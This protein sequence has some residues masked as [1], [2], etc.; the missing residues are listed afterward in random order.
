M[1]L[2]S[3]QGIGQVKSS[4]LGYYEHHGHYLYFKHYNRHFLENYF[5]EHHNIISTSRKGATIVRRCA[6]VR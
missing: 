2:C 1:Y 3:I 4:H 6:V 5:T